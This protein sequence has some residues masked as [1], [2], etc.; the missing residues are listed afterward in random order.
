MTMNA[1]C[2]QRFPLAAG[3]KEYSIDRTTS[4]LWLP[5]LQNRPDPTG[6][7][8]AVVGRIDQN[9][10]RKGHSNHIHERGNG[11]SMGAQEGSPIQ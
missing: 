3:W 7:L 4:L 10:L 11:L 1:H 2:V 5:N 6:Q 8:Q 9:G